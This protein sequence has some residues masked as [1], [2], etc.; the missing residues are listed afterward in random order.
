MASAVHPK[1]LCACYSNVLTASLDDLRKQDTLCDVTIKIGKR[2]FRAHRAVLAASSSY[3][4]GM[5]TRGFAESH[6]DEITIEGNAAIFESLLQFAYTGELDITDVTAYDIIAMA[7]Y[8]QFT[9]ARDSALTYVRRSVRISPEDAFKITLLDFVD[10]KM[11]NRLQFYLI[12]EVKALDTSQIFLQEATIEYMMELME[13]KELT[14]VNET[15]VLQTL[16]CWLR[17]DWENRQ[18]H[19]TALIEKIQLKKVSRDVLQEVVTSDILAQLQNKEVLNAVVDRMQD[20][21]S[22]MSDMN[23]DTTITA[24]ITVGSTG[25]LKFYDPITFD[26]DNVSATNRTSTGWKEL[27]QFAALP[28]IYVCGLYTLQSVFLLVAKGTLYANVRYPGYANVL[29]RYRSDSNHWQRVWEEITSGFIAIQFTQVVYL[30]PSFYYM[31]AQYDINRFSPNNDKWELVGALR[32]ILSDNVRMISHRGQIFI[33][34]Q[35]EKNSLYKLFVYDPEANSW[36][37][38]IYSKAPGEINHFQSV[39]P[40]MLFELHGAC[41]RIMFKAYNDHSRLDLYTPIVHKLNFQIDNGTTLVQL[42]EEEYQDCIPANNIGAFQINGDL[43]VSYD[44]KSVVKTGL[45]TWED[46]LTDGRVDLNS[47]EGVVDLEHPYSNMIMYSFDRKCAQ[48]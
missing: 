36:A 29:F 42:E 41:Y 21:A 25:V 30:D 32:E 15:E 9:V 39:L 12:S 44:M 5:F 33:Y 27:P 11:I 19:V 14:E 10:E 38:V 22:A 6:Q 1:G 17:Y 47:W 48:E 8:M 3:F 13:R 35:P 26:P 37:E 28:E 31:D 7:N 46:K 34:G 24:P 45:K 2:T 20:S 16:V 4:M 18:K 23:V 40:S 43:F